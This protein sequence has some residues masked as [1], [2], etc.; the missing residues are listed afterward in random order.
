[1]LMLI[2][3]IYRQHLGGRGLWLYYDVR[4]LVVVSIVELCLA[5]LLASAGSL[6]EGRCLRESMV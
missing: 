2:S 1:M 4:N 5:S 6:N 3:G